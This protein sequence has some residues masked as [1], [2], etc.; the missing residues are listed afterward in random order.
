MLERWHKH[1]KHCRCALLS[2]ICPCGVPGDTSYETTTTKSQRQIVLMSEFLCSCVLSFTVTEVLN[3]PFKLVISQ[4]TFKLHQ[5]NDACLSIYILVRQTVTKP[6]QLP[7]VS[8]S[9]E[10]CMVIWPQCCATNFIWHKI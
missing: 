2:V 4:F 3:A 10:L 8:S 1:S 7:I 9:V 5:Q 6:K